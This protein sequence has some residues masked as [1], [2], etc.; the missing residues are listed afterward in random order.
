V[1]PAVSPPPV[2]G[3]RTLSES[4]GVDNLG[5]GS[6]LSPR[7]GLDVACVVVPE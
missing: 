2:Q 1:V 4:R 3:G 6:Y 5:G 7:A